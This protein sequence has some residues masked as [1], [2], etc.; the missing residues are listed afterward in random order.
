[1]EVCAHQNEIIRIQSGIIDELYM[2]LAQHT[3]VMSL[4]CLEDM[5]KVCELRKTIE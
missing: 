4:D 2:L 1:V 5:E 3:E